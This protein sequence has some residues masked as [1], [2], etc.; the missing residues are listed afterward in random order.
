MIDVILRVQVDAHGF[1]LDW[2]YRETD[3][4]AAMKLPLLQLWGQNTLVSVCLHVCGCMNVTNR[5]CCWCNTHIWSTLG[6]LQDAFFQHKV[7]LNGKKNQTQSWELF[8]FF[9]SEHTWI[10]G[11]LHSL[12]T[13]QL[14][15]SVKRKVC[16]H[17]HHFPLTRPFMMTMY[18]HK[19]CIQAHHVHFIF[20]GTR[21]PRIKHF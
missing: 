2:H 5:W 4:D 14:N 1:L 10:T 9:T 12:V 18:R 17:L 3:I 20:T 8:F 21:N 7:S 13:Q 6:I 16:R 19:N 11:L 15:T